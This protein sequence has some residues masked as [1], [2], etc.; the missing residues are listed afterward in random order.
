MEEQEKLNKIMLFKEED[1]TYW[2]TTPENSSKPGESIRI[3]PSKNSIDG[4]WPIYECVT[5]T[6]ESYISGCIGIVDSKDKIDDRAYELALE[7][8]EKLSKKIEIKFIDKTPK[9][10]ENKTQA[11]TS[12]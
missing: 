6:F 5:T 12:V 1:G 11:P 4:F 3:R 2:I 7:I 9:G 8:A 10:L